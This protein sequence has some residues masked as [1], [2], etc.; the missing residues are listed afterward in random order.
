MEL[1]ERMTKQPE[2]RDI[3]TRLLEV[4]LGNFR[5]GD[6]DNAR[7]AYKAMIEEEG[8]DL[9]NLAED[10]VQEG[11]SPA[12][13][14]M[15]CPD[16]E[17]PKH[18]IVVDGNRRFTALKLLEKPVLADGTSVHRRFTA[19][20]KEYSKSPVK[21]VSAVIFPDKQTAMPWIR[22]LHQDMGGR[23]MSQWKGHATARA[24]AF[25]GRVRASMAVI[26]FVKAHGQLAAATEKHLAGRTTNLDRVLQMPYMKRALGVSIE[27]DGTVSFDSGNL[28]AGVGLLQRMLKSMAAPKFNVNDI[29]SKEQREDF[30]DGFAAHNVLAS[31]PASVGGKATRAAAKTAQKKIAR[32][33]PPLADR[34]SLALKGRSCLLPVRDPRLAEL[35]DEALR[36][37][38][39]RLPN[40][41]SILTRVFLE[42]ATDHLLIELKVPLPA[43]HTSKQRKHWSDKGISLEEKIKHV[44]AK[45][46]PAGNDRD[47]RQ[48]RQ[49]KDAGAIHA[50]NALHDF[51][52]SLKAKPNPK[53]VKEVWARWHPY[54]EHL[55]AA[56]P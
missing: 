56:L 11:L 23:G 14:F 2:K 21:K 31:E 55:F 1:G 16:P 36:I 37:D 49:Y 25:G 34:K 50:V 41:A 46:D 32:K 40:C 13:N 48:V 33:A 15:V 54:F 9:A 47:L 20:S 3:E 5:I 51:I 12:L 35:Y 52:H 44:L 18:F 38:P 53:E 19:L 24:D 22:R 6:F 4:D 10:I 8:A 42:Q 26:D 27:K 7:A 45:I 28:S 30:I 29:R 39:A 43:I 17:T